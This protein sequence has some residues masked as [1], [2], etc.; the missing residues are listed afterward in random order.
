VKIE[1]N[2]RRSEGE[3]GWLISAYI[4]DNYRG[5]S[6]FIYY[7]KREALKLARQQARERGGLGIWA[8]A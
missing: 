6:L 4:D 5:E 2:A 1:L 8:N 7:T 3:P